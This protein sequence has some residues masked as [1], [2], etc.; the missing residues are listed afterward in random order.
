M[1]RLQTFALLLTLASMVLIPQS[2][3]MGGDDAHAY[4]NKVEA[5]LE[6]FDHAPNDSLALLAVAYAETNGTPEERLQAWRLAGKM[7]QRM[8]DNSFWSEACRMAV[9]SIDTTQAFDT[10]LLANALSDYAEVL[11]ETYRMDQARQQAARAI[12]LTKEMGDSVH[13]MY[14]RAL[15]FYWFQDFEMAWKAHGYL[16]EHGHR[17]L[18]E[19]C[20]FPALLHTEGEGEFLKQ[21]NRFAQ[22]TSYN[23]EHPQSAR[24]RLFWGKKAQTFKN[25]GERDSCLYYLRKSADAY[26]HRYEG[27]SSYG[28]YEL[29]YAFRDFGQQDSADYY[30][31]RCREI[32]SH[33]LGEK[34]EKQGMELSHIYQS[35]RTQMEQVKQAERQLGTIALIIV[36]V[37]VIVII[38]VLRQFRLRRQHR[39]LLQQNAEYAALV[40]SLR[41]TLDTQRVDTILDAPIVKRFH[42][43]SSRDAHPSLE[44][45][46]QLQSLVEEQYPQ[47]FPTLQK[48]YT[49]T[50]PEARIICLIVAKCAPSQ[51]SVLMVYTRGSIS[52]LRRRLYRKL[53]GKDGSG[54]DLDE[55]VNGLC[56]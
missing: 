17:Q 39:E 38:L 23:I 1:K 40:S 26:M 34:T 20:I 36:I 45:W 29:A 15:N 49:L 52:N 12:R 30:F 4:I 55:L 56:K 31:Q 11:F 42:E 33:S 6:D 25:M 18:A 19:D 22:Y 47:L 27:V 3:T 51:M 13:T 48:D 43:L 46:Q 35:L 50:E 14:L 21:L 28:M 10:L 53:T 2:C 7:Y 8:G 41:T 9:A 44:E 54:A 37:I 16:W 32:D 5:Q 24:A